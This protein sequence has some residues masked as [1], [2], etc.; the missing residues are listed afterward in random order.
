MIIN[1]KE[2]PPHGP[3]THIKASSNNNNNNNDDNNNNNHDHNKSN[4]K[5]RRRSHYTVPSI[6]F[7]YEAAPSIREDEAGAKTL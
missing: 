7:I 2:A 4:K 5:G 6:H 3:T 1:N